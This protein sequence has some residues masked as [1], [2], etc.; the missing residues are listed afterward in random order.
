MVDFKNIPIFIISYNRLYD[1]QQL[2]LRLE[3][4]AYTNIIILDNAS[5]DKELLDYLHNLPYKVHLLN[6]NFGHRVLWQCGLF[7]EII[8]KN[9]YVLT[10]P[11][12]IP[13]EECPN[14]YIEHFYNI[15]QLYP[16][17]GKVGF[18]LKIDDLPDFFVNKYDI[19]RW[20]SFFYDKELSQ[21][22][23]FYDADIDTT[24]ALYRPGYPENFYNAIRTGFPYT[25]RHLGWYIDN[26]KYEVYFKSANSSF[27]SFDDSAINNIRFAII[28]K[29]L[30]KQK[31]ID[32]YT[33]IKKIIK[34]EW[35]KEVITFKAIF[36]IMVFLVSK[37]IRQIFKK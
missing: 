2:I 31:N 36:K 28:S 35:S 34:P 11:D 33:L 9:Y 23:L 3:K 8:E 17:K 21:N 6:K 15:L 16:Q 20:E 37:K 32:L 27:S 19:I 4:D 24:F 30:E 13:V 22:P 14:N 5:T 25:A 7:N 26:K 18:S 1:L 12:I 10:D 29:L